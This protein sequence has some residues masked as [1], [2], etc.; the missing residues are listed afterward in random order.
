MCVRSNKYDII[1]LRYSRALLFFSFCVII[2][3]KYLI[4][5]RTTSRRV[6]MPSI[7]FVNHKSLSADYFS[8]LAAGESALIVTDG[9]ALHEQ[10]VNMIPHGTTLWPLTS[11]GDVRVY[12]VTVRG[13]T[14]GQFIDIAMAFSNMQFDKAEE[15]INELR[16]VESGW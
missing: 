9:V 4:A 3:M 12:R 5:Y 1:R 11:T 16:H 13:Y 7:K 15:L 6:V 14:V 2:D 8:H 10:L